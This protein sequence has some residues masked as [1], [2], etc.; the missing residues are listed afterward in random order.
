MSYS[1]SAADLGNI[2]LN[3]S[4][5]VNAVLQNIALI[6]A[7]PKGS[8]PMYRDFGLSQEFL[9]KPIPVAK[10]MLVAEVREA[11]EIWEPR[12]SVSDISFSQN[13]LEPGKLDPTV[14]VEIRV[15]E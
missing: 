11:I 14:Q 2:R 1:V 8:V 7:T 6:L 5:T 12:A 15:E 9:D 10:A 13:A 4:E 3:E